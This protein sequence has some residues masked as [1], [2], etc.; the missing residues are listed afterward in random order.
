VFE[1][2]LREKALLLIAA[3]VLIPLLLMRFVLLPLQ[4]HQSQQYQRIQTLQ[5]RINQLYRLGQE[6]Q[7]LQQVHQAQTLSLS[8]RID[9]ILRQLELASRSTLVV[10]QT[11]GK[12][13]RLVLKLEDINLTDLMQLIYRI[14]D[15]Q[16][17]I[18][19]ESIDTNPAFQ[20]KRLFRVSMALSSL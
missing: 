19:I 6:Y 4:E 14:E 2:K 8:K 17:V 12:G 16:P 3:I 13:Q 5:T 15:A 20:N 1:L 10:E 9:A 18:L 7:A 11:P